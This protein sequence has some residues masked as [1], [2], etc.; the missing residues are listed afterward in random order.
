LTNT[1]LENKLKVSAT[2][3]NWK[4]SNKLLG[5]AE[6]IANKP[7]TILTITESNG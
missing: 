6:E 5:I 3:R 2:T 1:F 7:D 4:T